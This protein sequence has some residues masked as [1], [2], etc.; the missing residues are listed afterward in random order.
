MKPAKSLSLLLT[1]LTLMICAP[2]SAADLRY[3]DGVALSTQRP[4]TAEWQ[5]TSG[6]CRAAKSANAGHLWMESDG[7]IGKIFSVRMSDGATRGAWTLSG[8]ATTGGDW[9]DIA[10][11]TVGAQSYVYV[12]DSGNNLNTVDSRG[13]GIDGR[14]FRVKEPTIT[15]TDGT[16]TAG[17][18]YETI[19]WA[20]PAANIPTHRDVETLLADP[21][22]GDLYFLT[23]RITPIAVY[24]LAHA[25]SYTGTQTLEYLGTIT[26]PA[27]IS[28]PADNQNDGYVVGGDINAD[29]TEIVLKSYSTAYIFSRNKATQTILQALQG[30]PQDVPGYVGGFVTHRQGAHHPL[31]EPQGEGICFDLLNNLYS[32]SEFVS[33]HGSGASAH[34]TFFYERMNVLPTEVSFQEGASGYAGTSDTYVTSLLAGQGTSNATAANFIVDYNSG[35]DERFGLL[36]FNLSSIPSGAIIVGCELTIY[37]DVEG[38]AIRLHKM[39][40]PWTEASTYTSLTR[41]P[42]FNDVDAATTADTIH[43]GYGGL[44]GPLRI[45]VPTS[46]V[47]AWVNGS[48]VNHGWVL[49]NPS[50]S[51]GNGFQFRSKDHTTAADRPKLVVRYTLPVPSSSP[52]LGTRVG[53]GL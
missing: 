51:D 23:K 39:Y 35:T 22:T 36:K 34:P 19:A 4:V 12:C 31:G 41:L 44:T 17:T 43:S 8:F 5:E 32:A 16:L 2:L 50:T 9:E 40:M 42:L 45:K 28:E 18:D 1:I 20:F 37:I 7:T 11:A 49:Y 10:S 6:I 25:A 3:K 46:T 52:G 26:T 14:I 21:D 38:N 48:K 33:T 53:L 47:Q 30:T 27:V 29:G 15:G 13:A 24:R